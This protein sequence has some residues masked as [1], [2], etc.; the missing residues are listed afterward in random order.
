VYGRRTKS[1]T[2]SRHKK[3]L[4]FA[5]IEEKYLIS[6]EETEADRSRRKANKRKT[7]SR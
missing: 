7:M 2:T 1:L 4:T 6:G 3:A 5:D